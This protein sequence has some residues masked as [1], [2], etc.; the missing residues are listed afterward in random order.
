MARDACRLVSRPK[1]TAPFLAAICHLSRVRTWIGDTEI[2]IIAA[3]QLGV[4]AIALACG[5]RNR[6]L[7]EFHQPDYV[8]DDIKEAFKNPPLSSLIRIS[9]P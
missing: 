5:L 1:I 3:R 7:L 6:S 9:A 8:F 4:S 2:D